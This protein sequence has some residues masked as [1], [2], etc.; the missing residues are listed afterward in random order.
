MQKKRQIDIFFQ[1]LLYAVFAFYLV[2]LFLILFRTHYH[3]RS[4]NL[5]PFRG[6]AS[7]LT[8]VDFI[9]SQDDN[10]L[11]RAFALENI[12]GNIV[13]FIPL[14]VYITLFF[15]DKR[16]GKNLVLFLLTSL[17]VEILQV[18]FKYGIGDIDD[19]ILNCIGGAVGILLCR[20]LY[21]LCREELLVRRVVAVLAPVVGLLSF[22][23]L[24]L[25]NSY[26][27]WLIG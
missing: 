4:V 2:L 18:L 26:G 5:V 25:Y 10:Y 12:L 20:G 15:K 6:I 7:Y 14:G 24:I 19:V 23:I 21:R 16:I 17:A 3:A 8:G 13:I 22:L 11:L 27:S 1:V 9:A